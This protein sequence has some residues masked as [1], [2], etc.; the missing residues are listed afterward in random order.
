MLNAIIRRLI[1]NHSPLSFAWLFSLSSQLV[2]NPATKLY[3][4][5]LCHFYSTTIKREK[6]HIVCIV[7]INLSFSKTFLIHTFVRWICTAWILYFTRSPN[8]QSYAFSSEWVMYHILSDMYVRMYVK[9]VIH[10]CNA[11]ISVWRN[12]NGNA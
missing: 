1:E 6:S 12:S 9:F 5:F 7:V 2:N 4:L 3:F 10:V 11:C 8:E